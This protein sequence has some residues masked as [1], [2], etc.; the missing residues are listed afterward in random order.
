LEGQASADS[1]AVLDQQIHELRSF[2]EENISLVPA[3]GDTIRW[4][5]DRQQEDWD[6]IEDKNWTEGKKWRERRSNLFNQ[7]KIDYWVPV[8]QWAQGVVATVA[9]W[10]ESIWSSSTSAGV[11]QP[12][13]FRG[14]PLRAAATASRSSALCLL[15]SVLLGKY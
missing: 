3:S 11:R 5:R 8:A 10:T 2:F 6:D 15:R 7:R 9:Y 4:L 13:V 1:L 12:R 14:R